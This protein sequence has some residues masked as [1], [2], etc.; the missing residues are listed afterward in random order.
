MV[1]YSR[2]EMVELKET[3]IARLHALGIGG[4][5]TLKSDCSAGNSAIIPIGY[6]ADDRSSLRFGC[7]DLLAYRCASDKDTKN[8][9]TQ[10]MPN[11]HLPCPAFLT[12][13]RWT[14]FTSANAEKQLRII[15]VVVPRRTWPVP[16][17]VLRGNIQMQTSRL[18]ILDI[19][20]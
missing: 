12:S 3:V 11:T 14:S 9:E 6:R 17:D 8:K 7:R 1:G 15:P 13:C 16:N 2:L 5:R 4:R 10:A 20:L 19:Q 18:A